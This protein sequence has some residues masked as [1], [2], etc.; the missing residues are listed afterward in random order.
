MKLRVFFIGLLFMFGLT[1]AQAELKV[2]DAAPVFTLKD[3]HMKDISL[4]ALRG[5]WVVLY[6]Y[7]KD[8]TPGCTTEACS[9]RDN[10]NALIAQEAVVLGV[11]VDSIESHKEFAK[12][13]KLPFSLLSD[14]KGET[15]KQYGSLLNLG[16]MSFTKRHS[17]I[18]NPDGKIERIYRD[19]N[20]KVHVKEVLES[21]KQLRNQS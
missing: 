9:F 5:Q 15:A 3:Q 11:S 14:P 17:F 6:F 1:N 19:V 4:E 10:I 2:G 8:N 18:I 13:F 20:P 21:I 16:F 12:K 7:P